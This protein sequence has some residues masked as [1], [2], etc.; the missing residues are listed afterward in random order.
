MLYISGHVGEE[1]DGVISGVANFGVF[2]ELLNGVEGLI[3]IE[4][5]KSKGKPICDKESY[6]LTCGKT[7]YRLGQSVKIKVKEVNPS[8]LKPRFIFV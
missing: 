2:V 1:F 4:D 6:T 3:R 8:E 5:V 7:T